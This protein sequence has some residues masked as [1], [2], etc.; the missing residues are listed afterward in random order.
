VEEFKRGAEE[1]GCTVT[2]FVLDKMDINRA[3]TGTPLSFV[4][5][6]LL[7]RLITP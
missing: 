4:P 2:V 5:P 7:K 1:A 6:Q 3:L